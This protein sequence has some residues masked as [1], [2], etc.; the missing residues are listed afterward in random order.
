MGAGIVRVRW[1]YIFTRVFAIRWHN[2]T[3]KFFCFLA[4]EMDV[5]DEDKLNAVVIPQD[6]FLP[7]M[8]FQSK[9]KQEVKILF[10]W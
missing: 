4:S 2:E 3:C 1:D 7:C 10:L 6:G 9:E 8:L 5:L